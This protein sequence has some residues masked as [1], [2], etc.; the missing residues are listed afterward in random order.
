MV[1]GEPSERGMGA[2]TQRPR[3][4]ALAGQ[5]GDLQVVDWII[6]DFASFESL[7]SLYVG[8]RPCLAS[9]PPRALSLLEKGLINP[10]MENFKKKKKAPK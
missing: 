2:L 10:N 6:P 1:L 7:S 5:P 3:T 4:V 8:G 9:N